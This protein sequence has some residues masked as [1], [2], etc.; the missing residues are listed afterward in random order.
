MIPSFVLQFVSV[1]VRHPAAGPNASTQYLS[2]NLLSFYLEFSLFVVFVGGFNG[3]LFVFRL[4]FVA[5]M[6]SFVHAFILEYRALLEGSTFV[7]LSFFPLSLSSFIPSSYAAV[8]ACADFTHSINMTQVARLQDPLWELVL[9]LRIGHRLLY[10][11]PRH[12]HRP[13]QRL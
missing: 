9:P 7:F 3:H 5:V 12:Q 8:V 6:R 10:R 13:R 4:A 2:F 11:H 1:A